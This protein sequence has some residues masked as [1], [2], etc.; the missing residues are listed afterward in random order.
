MEKV[1][2]VA[3]HVAD[4]ALGFSIPACGVGISVIFPDMDA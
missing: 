2:K 3:E 4:I 1:I